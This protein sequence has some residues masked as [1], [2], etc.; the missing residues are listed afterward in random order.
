MIYSMLESAMREAVVNPE[1]INDDGSINWNFVD[2]DCYMAC[3]KFFKDSVD[4]MDHFN[5]IADMIESET[6][7]SDEIQLEMDL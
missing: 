6:P 7:V 5:E 4:Y 1:N 3:G 2:S